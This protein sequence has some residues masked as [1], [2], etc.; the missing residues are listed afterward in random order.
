MKNRYLLVVS[1]GVL[2]SG[3]LAWGG[4]FPWEMKLPFQEATIQYQLSGSEQGEETLY[5]KDY[6]RQRAKYHKGGT[7]IMGITSQTETV[8]ITDPDWVYTYDLM[9]KTG[10]KTTNPNKLFR[11]EYNKLSSG[12]K[13]IFEKN[14][15]QYG[16]S[17]MDQWGGSVTRSSGTVLGY[18]CEVLTINDGMSTVYNIRGTDIPLRSEVSAMGINNLN[19]ATHIDTRSS[20]PDKV[21]APPVGITASLDPEAEEMMSGMVQQMVASFKEPDG[22][23]KMGQQGGPGMMMPSSRQQAM[24]ADGMS[25]EEQQEMMRQMQKAMQQMKKQ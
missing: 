19:A 22:G 25:A 6:G 24:E 13:K 23:S 4:D 7:T 10:F 3:T 12:E 5:L 15:K 20:V 18:E 8:E 17:M 9:E 16:L 14:A 11:E 2:M 1:M 21:F